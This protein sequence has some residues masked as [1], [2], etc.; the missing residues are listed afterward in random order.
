MNMLREWLPT[1]VFIIGILLA[2][3]LWVI[4]PI[5]FYIQAEVAGITSTIR[6]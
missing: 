4:P 1:W 2:T 5:Q 6:R 3:W